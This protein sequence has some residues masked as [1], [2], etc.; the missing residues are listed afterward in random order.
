MKIAAN[1]VVTMDYELRLSDDEVIDSSEGGSFAFLVGHENIVPGL[2]AALQGLGAGAELSVAVPPV[3]GYGERD[4]DSTATIPRE[5]LPDDLQLEIGI[6]L[7]L[8]N[9][10]GETLMGIV[11]SANGDEVELDLN[12]PLAGET[13]NFRVK[14]I[15]VRNATAQELAHGHVHGAGGHHH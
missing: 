12:H 7:E 10:A 4:E 8:E 3:S 5:A 6:P 15:D 14:I 9:E 11:K 1:T 2:E 13:L